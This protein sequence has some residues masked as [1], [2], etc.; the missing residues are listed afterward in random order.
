MNSSLERFALITGLLV[1]AASLHFIVS[2]AGDAACLS[3]AA[4]LGAV[5]TFLWV[6]FDLPHLHVWSVAAI[7]AATMLAGTLVL[8]AGFGNEFWRWPAPLLAGCA[9]A[10]TLALQTRDRIRCTLC[11]RRLKLQAVTFRCPRCA[12]LVCDE[13]CWDFEQR[14]CEMCLENRVPVLPMQDSWWNRITGPRATHGRCQICMASA[15]QSDLRPCAKCRRLQCRECW[16]FSN[17]ECVRCGA[18]LP[19]LPTSLREIVT[20][21]QGEVHILAHHPA[22]E[23]PA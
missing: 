3:G 2:L 5:G 7:F 18:A 22:S 8:Q 9:S 19:E 14:R 6:R 20:E 1:M 23:N 21:T 4:V 11:N 13:R 12:M 15:E 10:A 17:G 16:D